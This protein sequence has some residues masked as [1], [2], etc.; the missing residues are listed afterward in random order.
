MAVGGKN[1]DEECF[2][3]EDVDGADIRTAGPVPG[4]TENGKIYCVPA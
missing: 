4:V 2:L 1:D 3:V